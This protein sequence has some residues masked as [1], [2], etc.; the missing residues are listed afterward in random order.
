SAQ[1]A[2]DTGWT[3][4]YRETSPQVNDLVHTKIDIRFDYGKSYAYGKVW[5]TLKPHFYPT[6]SLKLDAK[7]MDIKNVSIVKG[8]ANQPLKYNYDGL[9]LRINLD[10]SYSRND[11]YI[12]YVDY[13]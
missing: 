7:G 4:V 13:V 10:K 11:K 2:E 5:L 3:K 8:S 12:V 9:E 6:D 1:E